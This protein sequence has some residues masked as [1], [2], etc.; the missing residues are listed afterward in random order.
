MVGTKDVGAGL[1]SAQRR[2]KNFQDTESVQG[3]GHKARPYRWFMKNKFLIL[4]MAS[5]IFFFPIG[6]KKAPD[7]HA[8]IAGTE[9]G[10]I[11]GY[12]CSM[13]PWVRSDK[14]GTCPACG[15]ALVPFYAEGEPPPTVEVKKEKKILYYVDP[16]HPWYKSDKPGKAPDCGMDLV[17]VYEEEIPS[18]ETK[19]SAGLDRVPV[20]LS[21]S[22]QQ[23]IGIRTEEVRRRPLVR[24]IESPGRVAFDPDLYVAQAEYLI[25]RRTGGGDLNGLQG[26]LIRASRA[27]LQLLGMSDGQ[28]RELERRGRAQ[29]NLVVPQKGE[30]VWIYGSVFETDFPWV[31][32]D[33]AV[34]VTLPDSD[35]KYSSSI[36]SIDPI[37][38]P[39]TRTAQ[40]RVPLSNVTGSLRPDMYVKLKI[41]AEAGE[42]LAA[43]D[44]ALIDTGKR[45]VAFVKVGEGKFDPRE[46][47]IGRR[48]T[49]YVEVL[50][51]LTEGEQVVT[52]GSF[53]LDSESSM[54][55]TLSGGAGGHQH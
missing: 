8:P 35:E 30:G 18:A 10:K 21:E 11:L 48:G 49:G 12:T 44:S 54:K 40:I 5:S 23:L 7:S 36:S 4:L 47:K 20:R 37:I 28:I 51:G 26:G 16:M 17:P 55:A 45:Q 46:V 50:S 32:P 41:K 43:P 14:P 39:N 13:H 6:C 27:R 38:N 42:V 19:P 9:S 34:E 33:T 52:N 15:M 1:V 22:K 29:G 3:G 24:E 31:K 25:A 2:L 53:L